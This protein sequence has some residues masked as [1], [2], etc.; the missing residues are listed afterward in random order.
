MVITAF[1][2]IICFN[3]NKITKRVIRFVCSEI[4]DSSVFSWGPYKKY[5]PIE[6]LSAYT[7]KEICTNKLNLFIN[8]NWNCEIPGILDHSLQDLFDATE[9]VLV[10]NHKKKISICLIDLKNNSYYIQ[11]GLDFKT[12]KHNILFGEIKL[13]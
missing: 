8:W 6:I 2:S 4:D 12:V 9:M 3:F 5:V 11:S 1:I 7:C 13:I 10:F